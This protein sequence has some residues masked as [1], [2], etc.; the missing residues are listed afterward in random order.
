MKIVI[1]FFILLLFIIV[2]LAHTLYMQ[3]GYVL[4]SEKGLVKLGN[5]MNA[6]ECQE[7]C[8]KKPIKTIILHQKT[9]HEHWKILER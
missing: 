3:E 9:Y 2:P 4:L 1:G 6:K 8:L 7:E 5:N